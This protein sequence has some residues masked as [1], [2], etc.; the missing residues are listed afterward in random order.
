MYYFCMD[1]S[2]NK[3]YS[4]FTGSKFTIE[5][6][7]ETYDFNWRVLSL[8]YQELTTM[9]HLELLSLVEKVDLS[10]NSLTDVKNFSCMRCVKVKQVTNKYIYRTMLYIHHYLFI[11]LLLGCEPISLLAIQSKL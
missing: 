10:K 2:I 6:H 11:T 7:L 1:W 8:P 4:F 9:C 3:P 5:N